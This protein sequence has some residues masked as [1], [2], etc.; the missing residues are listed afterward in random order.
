MTGSAKDEGQRIG[1]PK[2]DVAAAVAIREKN[3]KERDTQPP[4]AAAESDAEDDDEADADERSP[5]LK[6]AR[7]GSGGIVAAALSSTAQ[8]RAMSIDPLATSTAFDETLRDR[9]REENAQRREGAGSAVGD[10]DEDDEDEGED[11]ESARA[12]RTRA[13]GAVE[14]G[15]EAGDDRILDRSWR[16]PAGKRIAIPVRIEPKVYFA[17]E[18]TFFVSLSS[19]SFCLDKGT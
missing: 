17:A 18:R 7:K 8:V 10:G 4:S 13:R 2:Q 19:P 14:E 5:F 3:L 15:R 6:K 12:R 11:E 9:L 16:A 1:L